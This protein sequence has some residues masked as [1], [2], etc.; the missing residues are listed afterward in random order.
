MRRLARWVN[1]GPAVWKRRRGRVTH[2]VWFRIV[3]P[4]VPDWHRSSLLYTLS[5]FPYELVSRLTERRVVEGERTTAENVKPKR[6]NSGSSTPCGVG[7]SDESTV[8]DQSA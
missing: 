2:W 7:T 3:D 6:L 4:D 5:L 1:T 8:G